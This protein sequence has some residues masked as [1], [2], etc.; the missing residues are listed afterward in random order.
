[1]GSGASPGLDAA[2]KASSTI[3]LAEALI[4][5]PVQQRAR[6]ES[7]LRSSDT[8]ELGVSTLSGELV[9]ELRLPGTATI[10]ELKRLLAEQDG[11]GVPRSRLRLL[12]G[13]Q[14]LEDAALLR[15]LK[16]TA[17]GG[18]VELT[19]VRRSPPRF[20]KSEQA[21]GN[22]HYKMLLVG[23]KG[24]GKSCLVER[25]VDNVFTDGVKCTLGLDFHVSH[26]T[27]EDG[28]SIKLQIWDATV[29]PSRPLTGAFYRGGHAALVVFDVTNRESFE[30]VTMWLDQIAR[31]IPGGV[32][33]LVGNKADLAEARTVSTEEA[34]AFSA[35]H[36]LSYHEVSS[37]TGS[38]V[39]EAFH[40][41]CGLLLDRA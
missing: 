32:V 23:D 30:H 28:A 35:R 11:N 25:Y 14:A 9:A 8:V 1:M 6:L 20:T 3:E 38:N 31:Y 22:A 18:K 4:E 37:K 2:V 7:A 19:L 36:D 15:G 21:C 17:P 10:E 12:L 5:I 26:V 13:V 41:A 29:K 16:P 34:L 24:V 33:S 27:S 40:Y 39:D